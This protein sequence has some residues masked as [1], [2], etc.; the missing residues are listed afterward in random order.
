MKQ[1]FRMLCVAVIV[2][3]AQACDSNRV[4]EEYQKIPDYSWNLNHTLRF[5]IEVTDTIHAHNLY[6][7]VRNTGAYAYS[8]MW[9]FL[10]RT[11][12]DGS[13]V[14]D[15]FECNLATEKGE[16]F[17]SGFGDIF[18]LQIPYQQNI[19][20][21]KPGTYVFE[22]VQGMRDEDLKEVVNVGLR[23]EKAN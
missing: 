12:P 5:E 16:W 15:K 2:L 21:Q 20:F 4:Y 13:V 7:N 8:N 19:V 17:G 3:S 6:V 1:V 14:E 23:L 18:D 11:S 22:I 10:K 9:L